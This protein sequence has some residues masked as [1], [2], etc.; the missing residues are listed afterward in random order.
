MKKLGSSA[1]VW[2]RVLENQLGLACTL[3]VPL[4]FHVSSTN[5]QPPYTMSKLPE[6]HKLNI[7]GNATSRDEKIR[8]IPDDIANAP[9]GD[10]A[11]DR[12][13]TYVKSLPYAVESNAEMQE[14]LDLILTR[15]AGLR[16]WTLSTGRVA[17]SSKS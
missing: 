1:G 8:K 10:P 9:P 17:K 5:V 11:M 16:H 4:S 14:F 12:L 3:P 2:L 15:L 13:R 7:N 6:L